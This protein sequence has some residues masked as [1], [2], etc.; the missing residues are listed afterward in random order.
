MIILVFIYDTASKNALIYTLIIRFCFII[1]YRRFLL[2]K[3]LSG[4][5]LKTKEDSQTVDYDDGFKSLLHS[6]G[7]PGLCQLIITITYSDLIFF[8]VS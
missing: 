5:P 6:E 7:L 3:K 8:S 2:S 4:F 1:F